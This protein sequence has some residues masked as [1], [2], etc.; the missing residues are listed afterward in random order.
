MRHSLNTLV[1]NFSRGFTRLRFLF[2]FVCSNFISQY[3]KL[4][5]DQERSTTLKTKKEENAGKILP[6]LGATVVV[7]CDIESLNVNMA[8]YIENVSSTN[9][10]KGS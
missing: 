10:A 5:C 8:S 3:N 6:F 9:E 4:F 7:Y 1:G 2:C